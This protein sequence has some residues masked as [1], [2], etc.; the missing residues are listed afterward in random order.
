MRVKV[1]GGTVSDGQPSLCVTCRSG[2]HVKGPTLRDEIT[3][4]RRF[5]ENAQRVPFPVTSCS[6]YSDRAQPSLWHL[7]EIAWILRSDP[8]RSRIGFVQACK[9]TE[10]DRHVIE[11]E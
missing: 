7:E 2:V 3:V 9:L 1:R 6:D 4:C 8:T 5:P 10:E 11:E